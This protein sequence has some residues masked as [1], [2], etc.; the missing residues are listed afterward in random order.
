[1]NKAQNSEMVERAYLAALLLTGS[2]PQAEAVVAH[3]IWLWDP[4]DTSRVLPA[5][6]IRLAIASSGNET[7]TRSP[8]PVRPHLDLSMLPGLLPDVA[9]LPSPIRGCFVLRAL[10]GL[11]RPVCVRLLRLD[12]LQVDRNT[13]AAALELAEAA[14]DGRLHRLA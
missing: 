2:S 14:G 1:M 8:D 6:A 10:V 11:P 5:I 9:R 3:A 12:V 4:N 13:C 7:E